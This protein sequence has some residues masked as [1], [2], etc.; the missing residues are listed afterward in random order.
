MY[1]GVD[2]EGVYYYHRYVQPVFMSKAVKR[3]QDFYIHKQEPDTLTFPDP[4]FPRR[5]IMQQIKNLTSMLGEPY[6]HA[7]G[8]QNY[9]KDP[10]LAPW[11]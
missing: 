7:R 9:Q 5:D 8:N 1:N 3:N 10:G 6:K 4:I 2:K 11:E